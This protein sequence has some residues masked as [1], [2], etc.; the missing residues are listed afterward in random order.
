[1]LQGVSTAALRDEMPEAAL[2]FQEAALDNAQRWRR[3]PAVML[4]YLNR[5]E[6][7]NRLGMPGRAL[8]DL[9]DADRYLASVNDPLLTSRYQARILLTRGETQYRERPQEAVDSLTTALSYFQRTGTSWRL[10]GAY[11]ARGRAHLAAHDG[12]RAEQDFR[13]GIE[14]F[15]QM[16]ASI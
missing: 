2:H 14:V 10:A 5:S 9:A 12:D 16:R 1:I 6:I 11:L 13:A 8:A 7:Y 3:P 15:E 4:G